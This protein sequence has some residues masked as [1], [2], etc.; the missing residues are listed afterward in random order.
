MSNV[1][2]EFNYSKKC[3]KLYSASNCYFFAQEEE[4]VFEGF[5]VI[6]VHISILISLAPWKYFLGGKLIKMKKRK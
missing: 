5:G 6:Y 4:K 2:M 3:S 1:E